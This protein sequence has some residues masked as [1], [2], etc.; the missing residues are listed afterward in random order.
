MKIL[1]QS[2]SDRKYE[3]NLRKSG[4]DDLALQ[5]AR[6]AYYD[7]IPFEELFSYIRNLLNMPDLELSSE[8]Y[9]RPQ[10]AIISIM[11]NNISKTNNILSLAFR[12]CT[13]GT[14]TSSLVFIENLE[15]YENGAEPFFKTQFRIDLLFESNTGKVDSVKLFTASYSESKN[16]WKF[17]EIKR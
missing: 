13:V 11:S 1:G 15:E 12:E 9:P 10:Y 8:L 14:G 3:E 6:Q 2:R 4:G 5:Q 7:S 17:N 16:K